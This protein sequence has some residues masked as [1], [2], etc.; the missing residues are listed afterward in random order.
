MTER[1]SPSDST[2]GSDWQD[3]KASSSDP[4]LA[5][6]SVEGKRKAE[7]DQ[8]PVPRPTIETVNE[9]EEVPRVAEGSEAPKSEEKG[10]PK[11]EEGGEE[12][13]LEQVMMEAKA[14]LSGLFGPPSENIARAF[15]RQFS[16]GAKLPGSGV[17]NP[18][19]TKENPDSQHPHHPHEHPQEPHHETKSLLPKPEEKTPEQFVEEVAKIK[20][21]RKMARKTLLENEGIKEMLPLVDMFIPGLLNSSFDLTESLLLTMHFVLYGDLSTLPEETKEM[22][23]KL[24]CDFF[25]FC[26]KLEGL[27]SVVCGL[28]GCQD[29]SSLISILIS[30][31][32]GPPGP[33]LHG[34]S[35][36]LP[37]MSG[38]PRMS[39]MPGPEGNPFMG[40]PPRRHRAQRHF[41]A[42]NPGIPPTECRHTQP[43]HIPHIPHILHPQQVT[44]PEMC[45]YRLHGH[46]HLPSHCVPLSSCPCATAARE[47]PNVS[48]SLS[49]SGASVTLRHIKIQISKGE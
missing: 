44:D 31:F 26:E 11:R 35:F 29:I 49:S 34:M 15:L 30:N 33:T 20:M 10:D 41:S 18:E 24:R 27:F 43:P 37:G 7:E 21:A 17:A 36:G 23:E 13:T 5:S 19:E 4:D 16:H 28:F 9:E 1:V 3:L 39:G 14:A 40:L 48:V 8:A 45:Q 38:V 2:T 25:T 22:M 47:G 42:P 12:K 46:S 32:F 6:G